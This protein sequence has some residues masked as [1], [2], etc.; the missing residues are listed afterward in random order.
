MGPSELL[1]IPD[2]L[3]TVVCGTTMLGF[4]LSMALVPLLSELIETL[5]EMD[6]YEPS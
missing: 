1:G 4:N 3:V 6:I 2:N 5:E